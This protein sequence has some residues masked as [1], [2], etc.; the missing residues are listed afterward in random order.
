[1]Q[2]LHIYSNI[3]RYIYIKAIHCSVD[4]KNAFTISNSRQ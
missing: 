2:S 3:C 1:M 4:G